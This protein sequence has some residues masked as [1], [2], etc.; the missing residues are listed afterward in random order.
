MPIDSGDFAATHPALETLLGRTPR[1]MRE[2]L[3]ASGLW[4]PTCRGAAK[5]RDRRTEMSASPILL[6]E[7][8][9]TIANIRRI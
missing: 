3:I 2:V 9:P 8:G 6:P 5:F 7:S 1:T 4:K